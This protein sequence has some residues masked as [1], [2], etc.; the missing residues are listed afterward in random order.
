[1][2]G[3]G[4]EK[5]SEMELYFILHAIRILWRVL[6]RKQIKACLY[7]KAVSLILKVAL[8]GFAG[9]FD[10]KPRASSACKLQSHGK[11]CSASHSLSPMLPTDMAAS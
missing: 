9:G 4:R 11:L 3:Q 6:N 5:Q 8:M 2:G 7:L 10:M 1:M